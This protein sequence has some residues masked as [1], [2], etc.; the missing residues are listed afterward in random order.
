MLGFSSLSYPS[1]PFVDSAIDANCLH[2]N[3][4]HTVLQTNLYLTPRYPLSSHPKQDFWHLGT[5]VLV[6]FSLSFSFK[7]VSSSFIY[8]LIYYHVLVV[9]GVHC[10][11]CKHSYNIPYLNS[12]L[13]HSPL[14]SSPIPGKVLTGLIFP[15]TH[16]ST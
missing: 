6:I 7:Q 14:S 15:C 13:H 9:L 11:I 1:T 3:L 8:L 10:D 5:C 16:M 4:P 2:C 12:P